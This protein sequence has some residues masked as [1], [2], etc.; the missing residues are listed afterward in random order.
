MT[1][2]AY[3]CDLRRMQPSVWE[4]ANMYEHDSTFFTNPHF[5]SLHGDD[6]YSIVIKNLHFEIHFQAP[7][8]PLTKRLKRF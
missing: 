2:V 6:N 7:K 3:K 5:R 1:Y 4:T 8:M